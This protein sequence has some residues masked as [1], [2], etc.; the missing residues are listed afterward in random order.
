M[1]A[2]YHY[3]PYFRDAEKF[4]PERW[5]DTKEFENDNL[6]VV[7]PF[8]VGTRNCIRK[9][10]ARAEMRVFLARLLFC[11]DVEGG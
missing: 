8:S 3:P 5:L 7:Q 10:L 6:A 2:A 1:F 11:F 4:C 9:I